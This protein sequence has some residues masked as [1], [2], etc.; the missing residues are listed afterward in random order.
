MEGAEAKGRGKVFRE[1][2]V[3]VWNHVNEDIANVCGELFYK[4]IEIVK[5]VPSLNH[6][7]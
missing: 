2:W 5:C 1:L 4:R 6:F 3:K 7:V